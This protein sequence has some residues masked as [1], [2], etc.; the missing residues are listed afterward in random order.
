VVVA[1]LLDEVEVDAF[2]A[3]RPSCVVV[4]AMLDEG[5]VVTSTADRPS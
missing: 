3:D 2:T 5:G 1:D 4:A